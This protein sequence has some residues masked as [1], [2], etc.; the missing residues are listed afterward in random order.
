MQSVAANE[1]LADLL[2]DEARAVTASRATASAHSS[3]L[4]DAMMALQSWP[5]EAPPLTLIERCPLSADVSWPAAAPLPV[6]RLHQSVQTVQTEKVQQPTGVRS[7]RLQ[8]SRC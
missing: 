8:Q 2:P 7:S 3:T 6:N 5:R 4:K 1:Q